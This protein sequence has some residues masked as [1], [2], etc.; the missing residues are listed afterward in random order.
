MTMVSESIFRNNIIAG[1]RFD[2]SKLLK[3]TPQR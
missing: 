2:C 1:N 3:Q